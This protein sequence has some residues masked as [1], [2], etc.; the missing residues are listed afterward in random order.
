MKRLAVIALVLSSLSMVISATLGILCLASTGGN[1]DVS[2]SPAVMQYARNGNPLIVFWD[3]TSTR[4]HISTKCPEL[5]D[6][7]PYGGSVD[8]ATSCGKRGWC[9]QCAANMDMLKFES[10]GNYTY[11]PKDW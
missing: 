3:N 5:G 1:N 8:E 7:P 4:I 2:S 11:F 10:S 6:R 9:S